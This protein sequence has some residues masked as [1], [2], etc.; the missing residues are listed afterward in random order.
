MDDE[1]TTT[2][3]EELD[4][5]PVTEDAA[6]GESE[7]PAGPPDGF[8]EQ[9]RYENLRKEFNQRNAL[10]DRARQGDPEALRELTGYTFAE[11]DEVPDP[12]D[13]ELVEDPRVAAHDEWIQQR[14]Q[15]EALDDFNAHLD[16]LAGDSVVL[17][18]F[19]RKA[20]LQE[21]I[22]N[23]FSPDATEAAFARFKEQEKERE[24]RY[25]QRYAASKKSPHVPKGGTGA[26]DVVL[27][28]NA[29]HSERVAHMTQRAGMNEE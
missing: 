21:S 24:Q 17:D 12:E 16:K 25:M 18:D 28:L 20:L 26:T 14:Q 22:A 2:P 8:I 10:I 27:P 1:S 15:Q 7:A 4:G 13:Q 19:D 9:D 5:A 23:G 11:D 29:S 6:P 3:V